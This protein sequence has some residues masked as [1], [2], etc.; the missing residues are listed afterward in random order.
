MDKRF[1]GD[2]NDNLYY[3]QQTADGGYI[4]GGT[5]T[6][7]SGGTV[8]QHPKGTTDYWIVKTDAQGNKLWDKRFGGNGDNELDALKQTAD[9]GLILGG[10]T[11]APA[12]EDVS[13]ASFGNADYWVVKTD[14]GGNKLWINAMEEAARNT[15]TAT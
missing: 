2:N 3:M 4:L 8:T 15:S 12:G 1:G 11:S 10:T 14:A 13:Q 5:T 7:D 9:G 6:S